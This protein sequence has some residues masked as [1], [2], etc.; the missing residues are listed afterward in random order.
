[1][2]ALSKAKK[3][4]RVIKV[5]KPNA[6]WLEAQTGRRVRILEEEVHGTGPSWT[7]V[8]KAGNPEPHDNDLHKGWFWHY[9]S[10]ADFCYTGRFQ[11]D[12][13]VEGV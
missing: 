6:I 13:N 2:A 11:P 4:S 8:D 3:E 12:G 10:S 1:M 9:C 5:I 7:Y